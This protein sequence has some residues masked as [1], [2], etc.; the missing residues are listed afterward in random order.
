M[1]E[2]ELLR[3]LQALRTDA[4]PSRDLWTGIVG[5][6]ETPR[7]A[8]GE[9]AA[10]PRRAPR[11][12][13]WAIA[14]GLLL[15]LGTTGL[16]VRRDAGTPAP[17]LAQQPTVPWTL[18]HMQA[19]DAT[20][21]GALRSTRGDRS[22]EERAVLLP[23]DLAGATAELDAACEEI[24]TALRANPGATYLLHRLKRTHEQRLR[25]ARLS[26]V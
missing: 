4:Q 16:L 22:V 15:A 18:V 9:P 8:V 17:A 7:P 14:A 19:L 11:A 5:R 20:Y 25:V 23:P 3:R 21:D 1:S 26:A 12:W 10:A 6:L 24:E 13:P 2:F